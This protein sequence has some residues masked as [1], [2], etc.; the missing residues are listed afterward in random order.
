MPLSPCSPVSPLSPRGPWGPCWRRRRWAERGP[1]QPLSPHPRGCRSTKEDAGGDTNLQQDHEH[2]RDQGGQRDQRGP[3]M[4]E[5]GTGQSVPQFWWWSITPS[6][7]PTIPSRAGNLHL[8][9]GAK[10]RAGFCPAVASQEE[11]LLRNGTE[12]TDPGA[13]GG[14]GKVGGGLLGLSITYGLTAISILAS[15]TDGAGGAGGTG[16]TRGASGAGLTTVT[17]RGGGGR[18]GR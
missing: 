10:P 1:G 7:A 16:S 14:V 8:A 18:G 9:V 15:R 12:R 11:P 2:Q 13:P 3:G 6:R 17:L 4:G 5:K